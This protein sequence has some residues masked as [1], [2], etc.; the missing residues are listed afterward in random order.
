MLS[1]PVSPRDPVFWRWHSF[2][3][4][5]SQQRLNLG[6]A[7]NAL[8][9]LRLDQLLIPDGELQQ[10]GAPAPQVVYQIPFRVF[11]Y[12]DAFDSFTVEFHEPVIGV[13]AEDLVVNGV[14]ATLVTGDGQ[15]PY[16]FSG[17]SI[18]APGEIVVRLRPGKIKN[19][20]DVEY[21]GDTWR[22]VVVD[23]EPDADNDGLT[24]GQEVNETVTNPFDRDTDDDGLIDGDEVNVFH[25]SPHLKDSD[26]DSAGDKCELDKGTDPLDP[27]STAAGCAGYYVFLCRVQNGP[28]G[29]GLLRANSV[30]R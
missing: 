12:T 8:T 9:A 24:N 15:G 28:S 30:G 13:K 1:V 6:V 5:V 10:G 3:D 14:A 21:G 17:F 18:P 4:T 20:A 11:K 16:V 22:Y 25:T 29:D 23:P 26:A 7:L 19:L 2:L 27:S